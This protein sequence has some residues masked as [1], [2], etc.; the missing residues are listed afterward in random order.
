[1]LV[2]P[3]GAE[4]KN[5][6][7]VSRNLEAI[8]QTWLTEIRNRSAQSRLSDNRPEHNTASS[9]DLAPSVST[10]NKAIPAVKKEMVNKSFPKQKKAQTKVMREK[11][12]TSISPGIGRLNQE[13]SGVEEKIASDDNAPSFFSAILRLGAVL[14]ILFLVFYFGVRFF[15]FNKKG[16]FRRGDELVQVLV[17]IP[18]LQGK[19]I[20]VV[21]VASQL[22][23]LGISDAGVQLLTNL[24]EGVPAD[25][26]RL[27]QSRQKSEDVES[28]DFMD[29]LTGI[30]KG[31]DFKFWNEKKKENLT[32]NKFKN[33]LTQFTSIGEEGTNG[34]ERTSIQKLLREQKRQLSR[35][36]DEYS[37]QVKK[38]TDTYSNLR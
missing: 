24:Q 5:K 2:F 15:R 18:L 26:I 1:M 36:K 19:F 16:T 27:W 21:D 35:E 30:L 10:L 3:I 17:S 25:R 34:S 32:G 12:V 6:D 28:I 37:I 11:E 9:S 22:L 20:Q 29:R 14:F 33:V 8:N 23:V 4:N 31:S 13:R 7:R 38:K